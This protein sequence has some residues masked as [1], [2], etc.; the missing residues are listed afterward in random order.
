MRRFRYAEPALTFD[1]VLVVPAKSKI[2]PKDVTLTARLTAGIGLK[3]PIISA[4]MDTVT[5]HQ[6][7]IALARQG[8]IGIIHKNLMPDRQAK[9]VSLVKRSQSG[10]ITNPLTLG[11]DHTLVQAQELMGIYKFS[12]VPIVEGRK[13]VGLVTKS[14]CEMWMEE[15]DKLV[16]DFMKPVSK[17]VCGIPD[18]T[19]DEALQ[20]MRDERVKRLPLVDQ[21]G[22]L[23]GLYTIK[24]ITKKIEYP[25]AAVDEN[26]RLLVG[27]AI[28]VGDDLMHRVELLIEAGADILCFD[29]SHGHSEGVLVS[30][31]KIKKAWPDIPMIGGN[32]AT[33]E[34]ARALIEAGVD[35]VKVGVGPGSICTTRVITG[36][37]MPQI[38]A[39]AEAAFEARKHGITVIADGGIR[40]SG[41]IV[42]ALTA[43][44]DTV[45][46]G[47][48]LAGTLESPGETKL[49][50]GQYW[51]IYRGM[52][53]IQA[54]VDGS[55]EL[56]FQDKNAGPSTLVPEGIAGKVPYKGPTADVI[57]QLIGGLRS[58]MG[59][60]G[61]PDIQS[62]WE[63]K[64]VLVTQAGVAE[65]HVHNV[66]ITDEAPNYPSVR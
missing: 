31:E 48:L 7:A 10:K 16:G 28:G 8:G 43:G 61:A 22:N 58:G 56:Y 18:M 42:R 19:M 46:V 54:M 24:D 35:A 52:G 13:L 14:D 29:S 51:K 55:A 64:F 17:L 59:R 50:K 30:I 39:V 1:D 45:M 65:S 11:P 36:C 3:I 49:Y 60:V 33:A 38:T 66:E 4:A 12:S 2:L 37:G 57:F 62:L 6:L 32:I 25:G 53:S 40:Y 15:K 20:K 21:D 9:E 63:K 47:S 34:G 44:A 41:D 27:A 5:E 26:K 23:A